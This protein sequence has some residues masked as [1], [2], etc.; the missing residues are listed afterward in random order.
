MIS[1]DTV[2][3]CQMSME[4]RAEDNGSITKPGLLRDDI[5]LSAMI[6]SEKFVN[7]I[8]IAD[9]CQKQRVVCG[10]AKKII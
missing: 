6:L 7:R 2:A 3:E 1:P 8:E 5:H 10:M 9:K 4:V